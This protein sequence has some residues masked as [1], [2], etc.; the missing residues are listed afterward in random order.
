MQA[1]RALALALLLLVMLELL[2]RS[3]G[4]APHPD[5]L[6]LAAQ[7]HQ[8]TEGPQDDGFRPGP[9]PGTFEQAVDFGRQRLLWKST[10]PGIRIAVF[11]SSA[12]YDG[13]HPYFGCFP[14]WLQRN[15]RAIAGQK[16][17]IE[18]INSGVPGAN[19]TMHARRLEDFL[20]LNRPNLVIVYSG[21]NE[22]HP[23]RARKAWWRGYNP[24]AERLGIALSS[25][26]L[27]RL[28]RCALQPVIPPPELLDHPHDVSVD[29]IPA[30]PDEQDRLLAT[31]IYREGL[32]RIVT[33][34]RRAGVGLLLTTV[35]NNLLQVPPPSEGPA[36]E[37]LRAL[38]R[39][40]RQ[41]PPDQA[42]ARIAQTRARMSTR[43][44]VAALGLTLHRA[45]RREEGFRFLLEAETMALRPHQGNE[46]LREAA[47]RVAARRGIPL[48]DVAREL[49]ARSPDGIPG[50]DLFR[51]ECHFRS[52]GH[53]LM[54]EILARAIVDQELLPLPG[55]LEEHKQRLQAALHSFRVE[56]DPWRLDQWAY[57]RLETT[58]ARRRLGTTPALRQTLWGHHCMEPDHPHPEAHHHPDIAAKSYRQALHASGPPG[59]LFLNLGLSLW[60]S[61]RTEEARE[62]L[63]R[64][65][66]YLPEDPEIWN[67]RASLP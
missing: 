7:A 26:H 11:G 32:E 50:F 42:S 15:L 54:G 46:A 6:D 28:L 44:D 34:T 63:D 40:L 64:A 59:P 16:T 38:E 49:A 66:G 1:L 4:M 5:F 53:R 62:A 57:D 47:R 22:F 60:M 55:S 14:Y 45:G 19:L 8:A 56:G 25:L 9:R 13:W 31:A 67:H 58:Q 39:D 36:A 24:R 61:G 48:C 23:I 17:P 20:R 33:V 27:Y 2:V 21:N 12:V 3:V 65:A 30:F 10:P 43:A 35:A 29:A 18:V 41:T 52:E 37:A 51:D